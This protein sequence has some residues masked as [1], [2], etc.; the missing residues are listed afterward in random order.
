MSRDSKRSAA[1]LL[2]DDGK[3]KRLCISGDG[4]FLVSDS[5]TTIIDTEFLSST[6]LDLPQFSMTTA[7]DRPLREDLKAALC[8]PVVLEM[9]SKAV[10]A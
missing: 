2:S 1:S 9:I 5:E 4:S 6:A 8:D 10:A 3:E 7:G